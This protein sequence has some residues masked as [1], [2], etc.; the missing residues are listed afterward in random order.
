MPPVCVLALN[1]HYGN[2]FALDA[3]MEMG[4]VI[5]ADVPFFLFKKPAIASGIG[6]KLNCFNGLKPYKILLVYPG[7]N[8]STHAVYKNLN[9]GLTKCTQKLNCLLFKK[10]TF[11]VPKHLCNDLEVVTGS[12][13]PDIHLIKEKLRGEGA[14]G[15]LMSGS[16]SSVFGLFSD[17]KTANRAYGR[18]LENKNWQVFLSNMMV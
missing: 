13:C 4:L 10:E 14:D 15:S 17:T 6:E 9:L 8:V 16:G 11:T 18:L 5:G 2:I 12:I 3:L 7:K 1:E